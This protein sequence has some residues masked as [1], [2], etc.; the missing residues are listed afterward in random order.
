MTTAA[1]EFD[2]AKGIVDQLQGVQKDQQ[3]KILR[4]VIEHL[5]LDLRVA[6]LSDQRIVETSTVTS[7]TAI[8]NGKAEQQRPVDIKTFVDL[9]RPKNDVQLATVVAY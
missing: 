3:Q 2:V 5:G 4:W 6:A 1:N 9:K 8:S 7:G